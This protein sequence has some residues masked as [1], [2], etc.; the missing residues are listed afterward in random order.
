MTS[1]VYR[2]MVLPFHAD[3]ARLWVAGFK[4]GRTVKS[5][6]LVA[7]DEGS[8]REK[9]PVMGWYSSS[10]FRWTE[11]KL[12]KTT[13]EIREFQVAGTSLLFSTRWDTFASS[14]EGQS[15]KPV[16]IHSNNSENFDP[17]DLPRKYQEHGPEPHIFC[18]DPGH[19]W[20][21][22]KDGALL[23]TTDMVKW[24]VLSHRVNLETLVFVDATNGF[25]IQ[26]QR[27]ADLDSYEPRTP[28]S[29]GKLWF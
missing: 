7:V 8:G 16:R 25:G 15:W 23:M 21:V 20:L 28:E 1:N 26:S 17:S 9:A 2:N 3:K 4:L 22:D 14:D 5:G 18:L 6:E 12:P 29:P 19:C 13:G 27:G 24:Q 10:D 11:V